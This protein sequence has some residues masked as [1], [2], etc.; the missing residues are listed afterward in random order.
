MIRS[1]GTRVIY[2]EGNHD[3]HLARSFSS[4]TGF[5]LHSGPVEIELHGRRIFLCHGD[6]VNPAD[7]RYRLLHLAIRN[8][9]TAHAGRLLPEAAV[10]GVRR[11]LQHTSRK[12]YARDKSRWDYE[13]IIRSYGE[14]V[15]RRGFDAL[16]LGHFH[17]PFMDESEGF[18][19]LSLGDW[20]GQFS[21]GLLDGDHF[22]LCSFS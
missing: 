11:R 6:L 10:Q 16:V 2:L 7:W 21:Y 14:K 17:L 3:F 15:K 20:I 9:L 1:R 13:A 8:R 18:T 4:K 19:L 22:S 5:E 12:R